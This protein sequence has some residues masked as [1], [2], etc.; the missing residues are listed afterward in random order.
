MAIWSESMYYGDLLY[1]QWSFIHGENVT[2]NEHPADIKGRRRIETKRPLS[3][4]F[5]G[6]LTIQNCIFEKRFTDAI[7]T[8][9]SLRYN[10][11][12]SL[13]HHH[14][15]LTRREARGRIST[16]SLLLGLSRL[17]SRVLTFTIQTTSF[18]KIIT[19]VVVS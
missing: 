13:F 14:Q 11:N 19:R 10:Y 12:P 7:R 6:G 8:L 9:A 16:A 4:S 3:Q 17:R 5:L 18:R 2:E 1:A 15:S